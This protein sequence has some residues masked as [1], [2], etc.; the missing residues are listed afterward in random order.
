VA[1]PLVAEGLARLSWPTLEAGPW[2]G[3]EPTRCAAL[4]PV[5]EGCAAVWV[6]PVGTSW[7]NVAVGEPFPGGD[8]HELVIE[9]GW[10]DELRSCLRAVV[11]G[12]YRTRTYEGEAGEVSEMIF[13]LPGEQRVIRWRE[14]L[15][16][17]GYD[18]QPGERSYAAYRV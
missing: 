3:A 11:E 1:D 17:S 18:T 6:E 9:E 14:D 5:R 16:G 4:E 15:T 10:E 7:I 8:V 12:R 2:K 13:E